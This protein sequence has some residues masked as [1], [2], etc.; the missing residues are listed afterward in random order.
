M[1]YKKVTTGLFGG[2][3]ILLITIN[4]FNALNYFFHF[5]MARML[6][7]ADYGVLVAIMSMLYIFNVA[8]E[9]IQTIV[10]KYTSQESRDGRIKN[11]L[12]KAL[13]KG[14]RAAFVLFLAF[15]VLA[16]VISGVLRIEYNLV[17]VSGLILFAV[18]LLPVTR[19][20]LQGKKRFN[21]LGLN[22]ILEAVLKIGFAILLVLIGWR[23]YGPILAI[24]IGTAIAFF[25]SF[26]NLRDIFR[27]K[28]EKADTRGIYGYSLPVIVIMLAV[29]IFYSLDVILAKSFF[30]DDIAGEYAIASTLAKIIFF[31][32]L[33][34]SKAMFPISSEASVNKKNKTDS[35]F[36]KAAGLMALCIV[37]ALGVMYLFPD[38]LVRIFSGTSHAIASGILFY[39]AIAIALI[40]F[41]NL[42]LLY[43]ISIGNVGNYW[44]IFIMPI[45]EIF[46]LS[47]FRGDVLQYSITLI[48]LNLLFLFASIFLFNKR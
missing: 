23:V 16:I 33:P 24:F 45:I 43:K 35:I 10:S 14:L 27:S 19:G 29:I 26:Y 39:L 40:S 4:I 21:A 2:S 17:A 13:N 1:E 11:I 44:L 15:L 32:T 31:G 5:A 25:V 12:K 3:V 46:M 48:F 22:M 7:I 37:I 36:Y 8:V 20:A 34:I 28:E 30:S 18:F 42:I 41:T 9:A 6:S 47:V 38:L